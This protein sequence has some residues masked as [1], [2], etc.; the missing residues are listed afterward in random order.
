MGERG[1]LRL[2]PDEVPAPAPDA[3]ELLRRVAAGDETAFSALYD[4][5]AGPVFGLVTHVLRNH[6]QAEEVA[7]E[8][9]VLL[10]S[11]LP[12]LDAAHVYQ[13]WLIGRGGAHSAGLMTAEPAQRMLVTELPPGTDRIGITVE[14]AGGSPGPTTPAVTRISLTGA[15]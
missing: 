9:L 11:G 14:P 15:S 1:R 3:E 12:A 2:R 6:A 5:I 7:Q 4:L 8:V 10:A 13:V